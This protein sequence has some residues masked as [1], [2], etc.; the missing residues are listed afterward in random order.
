M[1]GL[2]SAEFK[3]LRKSRSLV[4]CIILAA[5]LGVGFA[6][7]YK[8]FWDEN[9]N[10]SMTY[11]MMQTYGMDTEVLDEALKMIPKKNLWSYINVFLS[12]SM[13]WMLSSV[14]ACIFIASEYDIGT[15]KNSVSRGCEKWK[16][17]FSKYICGVAI[18]LIIAAVYTAAGAITSVFYAK[19]KAEIS[20][21]NI[22]LCIMIYLLLFAALAAF[23]LMLAVIFKRS[24]LTVAVAIVAPMLFSALMN[25][26]SMVNKDLGN[27]SRYM[28]VE[29]F[30]YV[31]SSVLEGKAYIPVLTAACYIAVS[32]IIGYTVFR[33][34]EVK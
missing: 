28:L 34:S 29:S 12:D 24:G 10:I 31:Q 7:L 17:Y 18:I 4:V 13:I 2:I 9:K 14:C 8:F 3:R 30:T 1:S 32:F 26:V 23:Y 5:A 22:V 27:I 16:I 19:E 21:G 25:T 15:L 6:L 11:A 33:K 20:A